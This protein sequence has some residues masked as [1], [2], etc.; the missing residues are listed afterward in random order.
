[1]SWSTGAV[2][3]DL[4]WAKQAGGPSNES[5][6]DIAVDDSGNSYVTGFFAGEA[7]FGEGE[8]NETTLSGAGSSD[9][10]IARYDGNGD[11]LWAKQAGGV[12]GEAGTGIAVDGS[13]NSYV[14]G[15][16]TNTATFGE[17]GNEITLASNDWNDIFIAKYDSSGDLVWAKQAGDPDATFANDEGNGIAVDGLGNSYVTGSFRGPGTFGEGVNEVTLSGF[18]FEDIFIARYDSAGNL[19]WAKQAGG[20]NSDEGQGMA[21]DGSGNNH[22]TG[23]FQGS[24][25]FGEGVNE[26]TL[27]S[28]GFDDIFIANYDSSGD[29]LWV[30]QAGGAGATDVLGIA[31]DGSGNSSV[32]GQFQGSATF[33]ASEPNETTLTVAPNGGMFIARY[34][35]SGAL[36]WAEQA[37]GVTGSATG[38]GIAVDVS[39]NSY[40]GGEFSGS[41]T[42]GITVLTSAGS[43][44][45]FIA[46]YDGSGTPLWAEQAGGTSADLGRGI[47]V[48]GSGNGYVTGFFGGTAT[49]DATNLT[50]DG[51]GDIFIA[52]YG[53]TFPDI[54]DD[55]IADSSDNCVLVE[56]ADQRDTDGDD[57][58]NVCDPDV[59]APSNCL[60]D[61]FDVVVYKQ[62]FLLKGDLDTDNNGDGSTDALDVAILKDFFLNPPGPS[63]NGCN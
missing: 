29:L 27:S 37:G 32:T 35:S 49:F 21:V 2:A 48:D 60:V 36:M 18:G 1:M 22:V 9:I 59:A 45:I 40:V 39:G 61:F 13:G 53:D 26:V 31:V 47:G 57:I 56:N 52:K 51:E 8:V 41:A 3:Q 50:S 4:E 54:D 15:S 19:S 63:A 25:T 62:N 17:V 16:F 46:K 58:G 38:T 44:D 5:G 28:V 10:F 55:G 34:D 6:R 14:T 12:S 24:A 7:T 11:L 33:G 42:F 43:E 30:K 23:Q 20:G